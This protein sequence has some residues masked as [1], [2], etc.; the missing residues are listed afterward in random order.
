MDHMKIDYKTQKVV[1]TFAGSLTAVSGIGASASQCVSLARA[2]ASAT[3]RKMT[4]EEINT[5]GYEGEKGY[6]GTPSGIDNTA[7]TY[8]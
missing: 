6:H 7:A 5:A 2:L 1:A 3:G 8:G 4:E